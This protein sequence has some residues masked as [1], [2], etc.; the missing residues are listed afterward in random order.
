MKRPEKATRSLAMAA[1]C[2]ECM[3]AYADSIQDCANP[4]CPLYQWMPRRKLEPVLKWLEHNP[5]KKGQ[6]LWADCGREL[7]E[8]QKTEARDRLERARQ[9][10]KLLKG[11]DL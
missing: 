4:E 1:K 11:L 7:T 5:R 6:V 9:K 8:E 2:H 3:G 10:S